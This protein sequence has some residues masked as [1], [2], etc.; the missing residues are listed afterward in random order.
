MH[1]QSAAVLIISF[2]TKEVKELGISHRNEKI[3]AVIRITHDQKE[4]CF[5]VTQGI[6]LQFVIVGDFTKFGYIEH[7]QTRSAG[8]EDGFS[9]LTGG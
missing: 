9:S 3:E 8:N 5:S 6:Q 1:R 2:F 7:S 4:G